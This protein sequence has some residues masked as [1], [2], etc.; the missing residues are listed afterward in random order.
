MQKLI[1]SITTVFALLF[2]LYSVIFALTVNNF[3]SETVNTEVQNTLVNV[4]STIRPSFRSVEPDDLVENTNEFRELKQIIQP[5]V[6]LNDRILIYSADGKRVYS[7]GNEQLSNDAAFRSYEANMD[8]RFEQETTEENSVIYSY[9]ERISN[10]KGE[11]LGYIQVLRNFPMNEQVQDNITKIAVFMGLAAV[12]LLVAFFMHFNRKM[13]LPMA[14]I[15]DQLT[16]MANNDYDVQY[17]KVDIKE[18]D[19]IGENINILADE[20]AL[21][22]FQISSQ[23]HRMNKLVEAMM[24][25]VV[26]VDSNH[27][28]QLANPAVYDILGLD[29][30]IE[31]RRF[32]EVLQSYRLIQMLNK[33]SK[34]KQKINEEIYLYY[35]R[36]VI[37]DVNII[38]L[39]AQEMDV[40]YNPDSAHEYDGNDSSEQIILLIYDITDIRRLE[41]VRSDFISNASHELK[42]PVTA[43]QGFSET[44]LD[45][46]IE[47][48]DT[49]VEFVKIMQKESNRLGSLIQDI[50]DLAKIEQ[51]QVQQK[52]E[53]LVPED[54]VNDVFQHLS[55]RAQAK[56][57]DIR[58]INSS[59]QSVHFR[60]D[61]GRVMQVLTNL[62]H[63]AIIYNNPYG[64]V[65]VAVGEE[66]DFV[67]FDISDNGLGIPQEDLPRI[68]ERFY[69]VSK[70]RSTASG[71]TG[72]GLSIVRNI[73]EHM[74][75]RIEVEST[76]GEGTH[77]T[78]YI[79]KVAVEVAAYDVDED[80]DM[81][82][83]D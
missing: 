31:G 78:V 66:G 53:L 43:L 59:G 82:D 3:V 80:E 38:Y 55:G 54:I 24:L 62:V 51:D 5:M 35:P 30:Q 10:S 17:K 22:E 4:V 46:A 65:E 61:K 76:F 73:I 75:G 74:N 7:M 58:L 23:A 47:D 52:V 48:H 16:H 56:S 67:R 33:A 8:N 18:F 57:I 77:F 41:K 64:Y 44:L 40:A 42:T 34:T 21:Q 39:S 49:A 36:E 20:L 79:P 69:R 45:G 68:F 71:G 50:L 26:M 12:S 81:D 11:V 1:Q 25:G 15:N 14:A 19:E 13:V 2:I 37:L 63:N 28:I 32:E 6:N 83:D 72:L 60:G 27:T 29:E 70:D 9:T